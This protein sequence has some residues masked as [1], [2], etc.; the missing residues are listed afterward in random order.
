MNMNNVKAITLPNNVKVKKIKDSAGKIIWADDTKYLYRQI[1]WIKFTGGQYCE[2]DFPWDNVNYKAYGIRAIRDATDPNIEGILAGNGG[3]S[4]NVGG[5]ICKIGSSSGG[6]YFNY[7]AGSETSGNYVL[8]DY[9]PNSSERIFWTYM[10]GGLVALDVRNTSGTVLGND[11][12]VHSGGTFP[13]TDPII[14]GASQPYYG[15]V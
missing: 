2:L 3:D 12:F 13:G 15:S 6:Y 9:F 4:A 11:E 7:K 5:Y 10:R 1:E 14:I 8:N